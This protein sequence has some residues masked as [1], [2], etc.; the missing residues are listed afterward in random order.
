MWEYYLLEMRLYFMSIQ[1]L[2]SIIDSAYAA[3]KMQM[4]QLEY[5]FL[6]SRFNMSPV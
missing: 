1:Y 4:L 3:V 6:T 5:V 2:S